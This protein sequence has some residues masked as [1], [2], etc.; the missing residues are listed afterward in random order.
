MTPAQ[1][2]SLT[3]D[4]RGTDEISLQVRIFEWSQIDGEDQLTPAADVVASPPA[5]RIPA[6]GSQTIRVARTGGS[7]V[8]GERSYRLWIDELPQ[9]APPAQSGGR[10]DVRMRYD[11]PLFFRDRGAEPQL[12][13]RAYRSGDAL[14]VE[15]ENRG[16][17][18]A[19]IQ[20]LRIEGAGGELS[21]GAGLN[22]YVLPGAAQRWTAAA[23]S[24]FPPGGEV[25]LVAAVG[26]R[27][28]RQAITL[29]GR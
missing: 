19:R 22:G 9:A 25:T 26:D 10:V 12:S 13:W 23:G 21:F 20:G 7:A 27:E 18:R 16:S 28:T 2:S 3:L 5:V 29:A 11:L 17:G 4:N 24:S 1:A 8:E 14:V 15:A 6:G